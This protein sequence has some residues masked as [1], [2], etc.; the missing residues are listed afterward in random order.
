MIPEQQLTDEERSIYEWQM[1]VPDFGEEGQRK[2]KNAS[3]MISRVGGVGGAVAYQLAAAGVG[4]LVLAHAGLVKPS[5][6]NRQL[7]VTH[8][9]IGKSRIESVKRRLLELNPRLDIVEV[10]ENVNEENAAGLVSQADLVVDCAPL[11]PERFA[12]NR[13]A[14]FQNKPLIECAMYEL[15]AHLTTIIPGKTPCLHCIFPEAP[16]TW[17]R[18]FPVFGAVAGTVGCM[19]AMEAIKVIAGF[20]ET[21]AG[22]LLRFDLRDMSFREFKIQRATNCIVCGDGRLK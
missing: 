11:F 12:M 21:M 7:L 4:R 20:G 19:G 5:D 17:T 2:L 13:Q 14:V 10:D 16:P 6:L 22:R 15:E 9:W 8:D 1:W 3:V 18:E